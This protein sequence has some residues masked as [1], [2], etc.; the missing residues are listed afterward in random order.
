MEEKLRTIRIY[1]EDRHGFVDG[2]FYI[3]L[4]QGMLNE[5]DFFHAVL[6]YIMTN[7]QIEVL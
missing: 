2:E 1:L 5:E 7:I 3:E 6:D 4:D